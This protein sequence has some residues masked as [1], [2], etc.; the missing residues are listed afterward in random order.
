[1]KNILLLVHDD[2]GQESRLQAALDLVRALDG[3][4]SCIDVTPYPV[5][6]GEVYVGLGDT[7]ILAD[8]R[9]AEAK[10]KAVTTLRLEKEDVRW[11]WQDAAGD[12]ANCVLKA[13]SLADLIVLNRRLEDYPLPDMRTIASRVLMSARVP[14][15]AVPDTCARLDIGGRALLAWDGR[16]SVIATMRACL[17]I[18]S[19]A[20]DVLV[21]TAQSASPDCDPAEA[22]AYL[23]RHGIGSSVRS[24]EDN[25]RPADQLIAEEARSWGADYVVMGAYGRGRLMEAFGGVTKRTL[26]HAQLPV[27]LGH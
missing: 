13:A 1:M 4:L 11:D 15:V 24:V 6:A 25:G 22:A 21:F 16:E 12:I 5:V 3:H 19:L 14:V 23:S 10:N 27:I 18:L 8:W 26:E 2:D 17:P 9:E 20:R 7:A